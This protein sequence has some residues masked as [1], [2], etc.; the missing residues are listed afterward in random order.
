MPETATTLLLWRVGVDDG[1]SVAPSLREVPA[2]V[3]T[4]ANL[5]GGLG[6]EIA[7]L[8]RAAEIA[9]L[10]RPSG[11]RDLDQLFEF[12]MPLTASPHRWVLLTRRI[13]RCLRGRHWGPL[14]R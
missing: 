13:C 12:L 4:D 11:N 9:G 10:Q 5:S 14:V 3:L 7:N 1:F 6:V 2:Q 8:T